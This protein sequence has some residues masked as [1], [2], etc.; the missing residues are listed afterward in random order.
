MQNAHWNEQQIMKMKR[1][2]KHEKEI[3][4]RLITFFLFFQGVWMQKKCLRIKKHKKLENQ[5]V[6]IEVHMMTIKPSLY[7]YELLIEIGCRFLICLDIIFIILC[8]KLIWHGKSQKSHNDCNTQHDRTEQKLA[9]IFVR[10][11]ATYIYQLAL[12]YNWMIFMIS[13]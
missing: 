7:G 5:A 1:K 4:I 10:A 3:C 9:Y 13:F 11:L 12:Q 8:D 2:Q 6:N